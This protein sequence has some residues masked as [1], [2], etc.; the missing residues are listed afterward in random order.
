MLPFS[1]PRVCL[2]S[3][4]V[5]WKRSEFCDIT[6]PFSE[7]P[8]KL[9]F[10]KLGLQYVTLLLPR[11]CL[12]SEIVN[13][14]RSEFCNITEPFSEPPVKL[15]FTKLSLAVCYPSPAGWYVC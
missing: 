11:V 2:L 9:R 13:W 4:I 7:P 3:E 6:E 8:V 12:L 5:N 1:L 14:K 15:R 10:T